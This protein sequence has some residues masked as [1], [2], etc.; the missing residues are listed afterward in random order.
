MSAAERGSEFGGRNRTAPTAKYIMPSGFD[1]NVGARAADKKRTLKN[2]WAYDS[3]F[4]R[5]VGCETSREQ[6]GCRMIVIVQIAA[7]EAGRHPVS[8][9]VSISFDR[10]A[11]VPSSRK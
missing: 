2:D 7:G 9:Q 1:L 4:D 11:L 8:G 10:L 6:K 3:T 5:T